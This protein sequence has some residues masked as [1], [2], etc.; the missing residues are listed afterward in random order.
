MLK[1]FDNGMFASN[2]Y[3]FYKNS[4]AVLI[5]SGVDAN[6]VIEFLKINNLTL[7]NI[8]LTHCHIDH[9]SEVE[10]IYKITKAEVITNKMGQTFL[11]DPTKNLS[12]FTGMNMTFNV[13][14]KIVEDDDVLNIMGEEFKILFTPGHSADSICIKVEDF[15]FT[16]DTLFRASIG[17]SDLYMGDFNLLVRSIREKIFVL[18]DN[19]IVY[20]GHGGSSTVKF[21]KEN[22]PFLT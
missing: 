14:C 2:S 17:R 12:F 20:P 16:G 8:F 5:D 4:E 11:V 19:T 10:K 3:L 13:E 15:L 21:E 1:I 18:D 22:N 9:I 6:E 7:K